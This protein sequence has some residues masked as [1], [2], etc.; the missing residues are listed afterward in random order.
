VFFLAGTFG[1]RAVRRC[2]VPGGHVV[3]FKGSNGRG[4]FVAATYHLTV[5]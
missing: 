4:F 2:T 3:A 1:G 5:G